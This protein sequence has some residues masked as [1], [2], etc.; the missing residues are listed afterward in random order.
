MHK[1]QDGCDTFFKQNRHGTCM[2]TTGKERTWAMYHTFHVD[3]VIIFLHVT[4]IRMMSRAE[5]VTH[6]RPFEERI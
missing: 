4:N 3:K 1:E 5:L 6:C 2:D